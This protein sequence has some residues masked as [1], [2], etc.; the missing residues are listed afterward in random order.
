MSWR[1]RVVLAALSGASVWP[2]SGL[3]SWLDPEDRLSDWCYYA[4][5]GAP[6]G[7]LVLVPFLPAKR[8]RMVSVIVL[9]LGS[10]L[11]YRLV[12]ELAAG[13]YGPLKLN[14]DISLVVSGLLGALLAG[15]LAKFVVPLQ[16]SRWFWVAMTVAGLFGGFVFSLAWGSSHDAMPAAGYV[17]WQVAVCLALIKGTTLAGRASTDTW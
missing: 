7:A 17:V 9:V 11:I 13:S 16:T 10:I 4:F 2:L 14:E 6:F 12:A 1:K 5:I 3:L 8:Q 15:A